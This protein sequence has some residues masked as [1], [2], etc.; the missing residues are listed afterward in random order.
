MEEEV[1]CRKEIRSIYMVVVG[2]LYCQF[3]D[4]LAIIKVS[5]GSFL[6]CC[7]GWGP[8]PVIVWEHAKV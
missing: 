7:F 5:R 4:V 8:L 1:E 6:G 2:C 3:G